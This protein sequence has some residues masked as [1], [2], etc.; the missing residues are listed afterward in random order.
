MGCGELTD[1]RNLLTCSLQLCFVS[2]P[3]A[4]RVGEGQPFQKRNPDSPGETSPTPGGA[5]EDDRGTVGPEKHPYFHK[6]T[7]IW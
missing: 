1:K 7:L 3:M 6:N 4:Q 5:L 2:V